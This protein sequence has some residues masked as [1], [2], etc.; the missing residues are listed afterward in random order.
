MS[1]LETNRHSGALQKYLKRAACEQGWLCYL[2]LHQHCEF[3][4]LQ[5]CIASKRQQ[6]FQT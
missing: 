4:V 3:T 2:A 6:H 5:I 1:C